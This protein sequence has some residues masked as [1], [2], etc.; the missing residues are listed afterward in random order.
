[1]D[2]VETYQDEDGQ[3]RWRRVAPNEE[4]IVPPESHTRREDAVRAARRALDDQWEFVAD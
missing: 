4:I 2:K 3:W 1:M